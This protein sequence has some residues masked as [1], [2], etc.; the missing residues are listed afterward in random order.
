[1]KN[2]KY[3]VGQV[4]YTTQG[5]CRIKKFDGNDKKYTYLVQYEDGGIMWC[6]ETDLSNKPIVK[7]EESNK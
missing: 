6:H 2:A 7:L 4:V 5:K 1:M 3:V